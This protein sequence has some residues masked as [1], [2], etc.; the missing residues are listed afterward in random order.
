V[1]NGKS[2]EIISQLKDGETSQRTLVTNLEKQISDLRQANTSILT[3]HKKSES[4]ASNA[5]V[6]ANMLQTKSSS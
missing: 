1:Q 5:T 2:S 6:K 4:S 3:E